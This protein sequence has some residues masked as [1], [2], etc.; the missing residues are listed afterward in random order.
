M[1]IIFEI[2]II[3]FIIRFL[4]LRTRHLFFKIIGSE[5]SLNQLRGKENDFY[6]TVYN[7]ICNAL[8]GIFILIGISIIMVYFMNLAGLL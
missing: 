3:R 1:E 7:D 6:D 2:I 5:K 8:I 4:G